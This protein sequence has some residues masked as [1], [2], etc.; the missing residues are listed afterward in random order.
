MKKY[1]IIILIF[2]FAGSIASASFAVDVKKTDKVTDTNPKNTENDKGTLTKQDNK[3]SRWSKFKFPKLSFPERWYYPDVSAAFGYMQPVG[4]IY[5]SFKGGPG[6]SFAL[7]RYDLFYPRS[8][9]AL[10]FTYYYL[11]STRDVFE[12][13]SHFATGGSLG[14]R[15]FENGNHSITAYIYQGYEFGKVESKIFASKPDTYDLYAIAHGFHYCYKINQYI[16]IKVV[17]QFKIQ[18]DNP[19]FYFYEIKTGVVYRY[20]NHIKKKTKKPAQKESTPALPDKTTM[21]K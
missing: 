17:N 8:Y 12:P 15:V 18:M 11:L 14:Y 1:A 10:S 13:L 19:P 9:I 21:K 3:K 20:R 6:G 7:E 16:S 2:L 5:D 4:K